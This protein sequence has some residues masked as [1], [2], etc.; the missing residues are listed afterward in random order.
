MVRADVV[1]PARAVAR[2]D[3]GTIVAVLALPM[4]V[5]FIWMCAARVQLAWRRHQRA[6]ERR[7]RVY[8]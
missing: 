7:G 3:P 4:V 1:P 6:R 5:A 2:V 8:L